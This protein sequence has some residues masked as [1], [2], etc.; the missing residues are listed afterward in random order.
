MSLFVLR[1]GYRVVT[2][3]SGARMVHVRTG[4]SI[5][6]SPE[7]VLL[8][9]R[10]TAGGV[11]A[12]D[13]KLRNVIRRFVTLGV[14]VRAGGTSSSDQDGVKPAGG[15]VASAPPDASSSPPPDAAAPRPPTI[16]ASPAAVA[17]ATVTRPPPAPTSSARPNVTA[18]ESLRSATLRAFSLSGLGPSASS[19]KQRPPDNLPSP[20]ASRVTGD[21]P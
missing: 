3:R 10:A 14:L 17:A 1:E 11:D 5:D 21:G 7:E 15:D 8:F 12:S 13:P 6:L 2:T 20:P 9:A 16:A 4:G 19:N 18:S